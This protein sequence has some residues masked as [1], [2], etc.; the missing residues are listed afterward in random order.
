[1]WNK[2][3]KPGLIQWWKVNEWKWC[4]ANRSFSHLMADGGKR[5]WKIWRVEALRPTFEVFSFIYEVFF[6]YFFLKKIEVLL[7]LLSLC[8]K[9]KNAQPKKS[10]KTIFK[11]RWETTGDIHSFIF[12]LS[13]RNFAKIITIFFCY[14]FYSKITFPCINL[15]MHCKGFTWSLPT[16]ANK[17]Q[18]KMVGELNTL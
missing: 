17:N 7:I 14:V 4:F 15:V 13:L 6:L 2:L 3:S 12:I 10:S 9:E 16:T 5:R 8:A 1:M 11:H 18:E